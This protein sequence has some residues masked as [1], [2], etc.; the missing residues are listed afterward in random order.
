VIIIKNKKLLLSLSVLFIAFL[1]TGCFLFNSL[2][3]IESTPIT[4]AKVGIAYTYN[5]NATD[6][7]GDTL[8]YSLLTYPEG[9]IINSTSGIISWTPTEEQMGENEV[10]VKIKDKWHYD[11]QTFVVTV[12]KIV[13]TSIEVLPSTMS[14]K[15]GSSWLVTSITANYD[16]GAS[17]TVALSECS[18]E[19]S[20]TSNATVSNIGVIKGISAGSATITV[21]YTEGEITKSDTINV[22]VTTPS[23]PTGGG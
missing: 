23:P 16:Y 19:S 18:Y 15:V 12:S 20:N 5:V 2:P 22:T 3:I 11:T 13:L 7:D 21:S 4:T 6:P 9:M 14:L 1:F 10:T 8:E 17:K